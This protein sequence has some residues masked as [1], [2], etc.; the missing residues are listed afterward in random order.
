MI[1]AIKEAEGV[2]IAILLHDIGHGAFSHALEHGITDN[3]THEELSLLFMQ[4]LNEEFKGKLSLAIDIFKNEYSKSTYIN[5][6]LI[7]N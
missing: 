4:K 1:L 6:Y 7:V 2:K 5:W 3:I